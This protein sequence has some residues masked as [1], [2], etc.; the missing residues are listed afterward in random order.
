MSRNA[1]VVS[2]SETMVAG[3]SPATI[4]QNRQSACGSPATGDSSQLV[5]VHA[6]RTGLGC[7]RAAPTRR[8]KGRG[9]AERGRSARHRRA[10]FRALRGARRAAH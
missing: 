10:A 9:R 5:P 1:T 4:L 3:T 6:V 8:G 7:Y 2:V